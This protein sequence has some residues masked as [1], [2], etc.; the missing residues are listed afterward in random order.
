MISTDLREQ[1]GTHGFAVL[2]EFYTLDELA[3]AVAEVSALDGPPGP[4]CQSGVYAVRNL[5]QLAPSVRALAA[6]GKIRALVEEVLGN[7]AFPVRALLFDKTAAANWLV[8]WHQDL[9]ICVKS[10]LPFPG[11]GSWSTKSGIV[12]VQPP[13]HI[14]EHML[15]VRIHLDPTDETNGALRVLPGSH[16]QGRLSAGQIAALQP[17]ARAVTCCV[18][19]GGVVLMKPLLLHA[20]SAGTRPVHRRVIH[21]EFA[22]VDLPGGLQWHFLDRRGGP[23]PE[24]A[25]T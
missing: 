5:L 4:R 16:N 9:S 14:L 21:I 11:F 19:R 13:A 25:K 6:S 2:A 15:A 1:I 3:P 22:A 10:R 8:P 18:P 17:G 20:S 23:K 12:H 24:A 7:P